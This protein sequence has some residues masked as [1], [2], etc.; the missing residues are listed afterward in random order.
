MKQRP[1]QQIGKLFG[2]TYSAVS[3]SVREMQK[4]LRSDKEL[5]ATVA[6]LNSQFKV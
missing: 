3:H 2:L 6:L 5:R 4:K 1:H